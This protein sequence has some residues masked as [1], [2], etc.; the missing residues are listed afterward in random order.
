MNHKS[1]DT[2]VNIHGA[3]IHY[4]TA[5]FLKRLLEH[6]CV[7]KFCRTSPLEIDRLWEETHEQMVKKH[8]CREDFKIVIQNWAEGLR[9]AG[10]IL[11]AMWHRLGDYEKTQRLAESALSRSHQAGDVA[12]HLSAGL[13]LS[14]AWLKLGKPG[15]ARK[16][17][18]KA[19]RF[20]GSIGAVKEMNAALQLQTVAQFEQGDPGL[21]F[22]W[23]YRLIN[24]INGGG[25]LSATYMT[26][27]AVALSQQGRDR[28]AIRILKRVV[29][30]RRRQ[31]QLEEM[32]RA[33][34]NLAFGY[35]RTGRHAKAAATFE[36]AARIY[37][38]LCN[39]MASETCL[40]HAQQEYVTLDKSR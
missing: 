15:E 4:D 18:C 36:K 31:G 25:C 24:W 26:N 8:K 38:T 21:I 30:K 9:S 33:L 20:A 11:A 34:Q 32:A 5:L 3:M 22:S 40:A 19:L 2:L 10:L 28:K 35:Q 37:K 16:I 14:D 12:V 23:P 7:Q 27:H 17:A 13:M 6:P 39:Q 1:R 29:V